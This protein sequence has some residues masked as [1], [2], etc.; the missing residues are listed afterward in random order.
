[1]VRLRRRS[2][3][4]TILAL[5]VGLGVFAALLT[6]GV[7]LQV[8]LHNSDDRVWRYYLAAVWIAVGAAVVAASV[9]AVGRGIGRLVT[10]FL[11]AGLVTVVAACMF[12]AFEDIGHGSTI[13]IPEIEQFTRQAAGAAVLIAP[14]P[15]ALGWLAQNSTRRLSA[16]SKPLRIAA[17]SVAIAAIA[18][19]VI[20]LV[21]G[22][23]TG[24]PPRNKLPAAAAIGA[25]PKASADA[26][27]QLWNA[28][29][30]GYSPSSCQPGDAPPPAQAA[31][32][33]SDNSLPGGSTHAAYVL[34]PDRKTLDDAFWATVLDRE[35]AVMLPCD[36]GFYSGLWHNDRTD[37]NLN[38]AHY[39]DHDDAEVVWTSGSD[40]L[41]AIAHGPNLD[42]L[43]QWFTAVTNGRDV[44]GG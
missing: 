26:Y 33:C 20:A 10:S 44:V 13:G 29:P 2:R 1:M 3:I 24:P 28:M 7:R 39:T 25:A 22:L 34:L 43:V 27:D 14:V 9:E 16:R 36:H 35:Q 12:A 15:A 38:C 31:F 4:L 11:T 8:D 21:P 23:V 40:R 19:V 37:G 32:N 30:E 18:A 5:A 17:A 41:L 6:L 42:T